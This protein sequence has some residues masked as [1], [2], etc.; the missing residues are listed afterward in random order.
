MRTVTGYLL[1]QAL[2]GESPWIRFVARKDLHQH[3][4]DLVSTTLHRVL[5]VPRPAPNS[6]APD[7]LDVSEIIRRVPT[8]HAGIGSL[9]ASLST[10]IKWTAQNT[11]TGAVYNPITNAGDIRKTYNFGTA[12][13]N[14]VT[15]GGDE[16]FSFQQS[17]AAGASATLDL[18]AMTNILQQSTVSIARIKGYQ[19]RLLSATDDATITPAPTATSTLTVT[20]IGPAV[21]TPLDFQNGGSGLTV[22]LTGTGAVTAVAIG[23]AGTGY[24]PSSAFLATPQQAGGSGCVFAVV[25]NASGVPTSVVFIAGAGGAGYTAATVPAIV[26]GQYKVVTGGAHMYF[27]PQA[28]GF[29]L[30]SAT[31][32]N[33]LLT[34]NDQTK[35]VTVELDFCAATT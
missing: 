29:C 15:G 10:E 21:P 1:G 2:R 20:N 14:G 18:T 9:T 23:S 4:R 26:A 27:D 3:V 16:I 34:N 30:V 22:A 19:I 17:I 25:T 7:I 8:H 31:S 5:C 12:A 35:A 24:P 6:H 32:K 28:A 33:L 13:A 11:L